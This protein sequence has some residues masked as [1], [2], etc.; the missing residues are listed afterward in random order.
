MRTDCGAQVVFNKIPKLIG[1]GFFNFGS[2]IDQ[3][4]SSDYKT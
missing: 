1:D 2:P 4:K 3:Y